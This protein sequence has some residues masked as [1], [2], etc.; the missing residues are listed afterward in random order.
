[1]RPLVDATGRAFVLFE[2]GAL[3]FD[4]NGSL[5]TGW[6][7]EPQTALQAASACEPAEGDTG[8]DI[9]PLPPALDP[10]GVLY[11]IESSD[12]SKGGRLNGVGVDGS[13]RDNWP[14]VLQEP[15]AHFDSVA[16]SEQ[17]LVFAVA[18][19][20]EPGDQWSITIL[21]VEPDK[22]RRWATTIVEP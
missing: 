20:T 4:R 6:P 19:E 7:Y 5:L 11:L 22:T 12:G 10:A 8:C 15:G 21:A 3:A 13:V 9:W 18:F 1:M 16:L 14:L 17:D 2:D